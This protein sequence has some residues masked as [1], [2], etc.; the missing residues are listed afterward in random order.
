MS[1]FASAVASIT[2]PYDRQARLFPALLALLPLFVTVGSIYGPKLSALTNLMTVVIACG[3]LYL[4]AQISRDRGKAL[5]GNL[6]SEWGGKP[7]TQLLRH[8]DQSIEA[9]TKARYHA[10]LSRK[11][12]QALPDSSVESNDPKAADDVY[13][14]AVRWLLNQTTNQERFQ[15]LFKENISY[16]FRRNALGLK[17]IALF[18]AIA[19]VV[20]VLIKYNVV[21]GSGWS[22][23]S[24][25]TLA[26]EAWLSLVVSLV[27]IGVW[28]AFFTKQAVKVAAFTYAE[29]LLRA[30]DVL[31]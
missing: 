17:P 3:G 26:D 25:G 5:E 4:L 10:F 31:E 30:C 8:R 21:A 2:D 6:F 19:C 7:S 11:L 1:A 24:L 12:G 20:F 28:I 23:A 18:F 13:Q 15:L 14:S 29:T 22:N 16:G 9:A 27:A